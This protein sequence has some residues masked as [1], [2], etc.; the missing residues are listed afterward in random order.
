MLAMSQDAALEVA[1][2]EC[3]LL[4]VFRPRR[5]LRVFVGCKQMS[6]YAVAGAKNV[7]SSRDAVLVVC[8]QNLLKRACAIRYQTH[9]QYKGR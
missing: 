3:M 9:L 1:E 7:S 2:N 4:V 6:R 5:C 8:K